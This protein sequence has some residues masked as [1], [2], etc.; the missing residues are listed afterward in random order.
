MRDYLLQERYRDQ[1]AEKKTNF[2]KI[3]K[4]GEIT[5]LSG[6]GISNGVVKK[7]AKDYFR[8]GLPFDQVLTDCNRMFR[9]AKYTEEH[10]FVF[11]LIE[12]YKNS[13]IEELFEYANEWIDYIDHWV[14]SDHLGINAMRYYPVQNHLDQIRTWSS[15]DNFWRRR[16]SMTFVLKHLNREDV[17]NCAIMNITDLLDD[18]NYYVRKAIPW[19]LRICSKY[20]PK[21]IYEYLVEHISQLNKTEL[22]E[23]SKKLEEKEK[24]IE[25]YLNK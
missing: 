21:L 1:N 2:I 11:N 23:A 13:V 16:Q 14:S 15:S 8:K 18:R 12:L 9:E 22:R 25:L 4:V 7:L 19:V 17:R 10:V 3:A 24:L 6:F 5:H 20:D